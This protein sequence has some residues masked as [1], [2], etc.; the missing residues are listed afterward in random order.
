MRS[1]AKL[2][3]RAGQGRT[4]SPSGWP[5]RPFGLGVISVF[6][7]VGFTLEVA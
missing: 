3:E 2:L 6:S 5:I 4:D 1:E 7:V